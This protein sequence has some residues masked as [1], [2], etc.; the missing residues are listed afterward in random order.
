[1]FN[2]LKK[3][4]ELHND[5]PFL[6][7]KMKIEK[8]ENLV[9]NLHDKTEYV[10][11]ILHIINL[12]QALSHGLTLKKVHRVIKFNQNAWLKPY[13][14]MNSKLRQKAKKNFEKD[15]FRLF[16]VVSGKTMENVRKHRNIKLV[17]TERGRNYL[18]SEPNYYITMLF[19][20][21]LLAI[22]LR[23]IQILMNKRV[24]LGLSILD[25]SKSV[26]YEFWYYYVKPKY[27]ERAKLCYMDKDSFIEHVQ[28]HD[29]YKDIGEDVE[30]RFDTSNFEIGRSLPKGKKKK[31]IRLMKDELGGQI[32]K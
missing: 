30:A 20:E 18:V 32:K 15:F 28:T 3:L 12:K 25:L 10:L 27:G 4:H 11:H 5:L 17:K 13:K 22:E 8:V 21:N 26:M 19:T 24:Y 6:P 29:I 2:I 31:V 1:M 16:G 9:T 23:K 7:E 14:D